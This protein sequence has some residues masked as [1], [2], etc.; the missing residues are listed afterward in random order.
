MRRRKTGGRKKGSLNKRTLQRLALAEAMV[1][2]PH[3]DAL[4]YL[5]SVVASDDN[6][7]VTPDLKLR[8]AI[9]LA[10]YQHPRPV[11]LRKATGKPI[12]L[13]PPRSAQDARDMIAA[14]TSKM[15]REEV[16]RDHASDVIAGLKAYLD[17]RAAELEAEV[18]KHRAEEGL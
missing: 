13:L 18:E 12:D 3:P 5:A 7:L 6:P 8:A 16:D 10:Q 15:A 9:A 4:D 2:T 11:P 14:L 17:A 1:K